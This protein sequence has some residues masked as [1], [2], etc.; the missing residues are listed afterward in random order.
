[1]EVN[2]NDMNFSDNEQMIFVLLFINFS[3]KN[4]SP[5]THV[6]FSLPL[7][8]DSSVTLKNWRCFDNPCQRHY[9]YQNGRLEG[10]LVIAAMI[11]KFAWFNC[12]IMPSYAICSFIEGE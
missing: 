10:S 11:R 3:I 12:I 8:F 4:H 7:M 6:S 1:M 2:Q 5:S 9:H